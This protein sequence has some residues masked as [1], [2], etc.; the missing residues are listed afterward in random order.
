MSSME[1]HLV[2][3][4]SHPSDPSRRADLQGQLPLRPKRAPQS[5]SQASAAAVPANPWKEDPNCLGYGLF[6]VRPDG[7]FLLR[8]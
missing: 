4:L 1:V 6:L 8:P 5:G 2:P 7:L 3:V